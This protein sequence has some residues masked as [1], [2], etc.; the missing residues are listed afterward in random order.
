MCAR[1][2]AYV[3]M[4]VCYIMRRYKP[5]CTRCYLSAYSEIPPST[6]VLYHTRYNISFLRRETLNQS[7]RL[8]W[9]SRIYS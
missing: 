2:Y 9:N 6:I 4:Y 1:V 3:C 5:T 7:L 8:S